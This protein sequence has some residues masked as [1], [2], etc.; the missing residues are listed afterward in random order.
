[1]MY[2]VEDRWKVQKHKTQKYYYNATKIKIWLR[3]EFQD[4]VLELKN[5]WIKI[6][7]W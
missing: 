7:T 2:I 4:S 5:F 3:L 1:M 6:Y